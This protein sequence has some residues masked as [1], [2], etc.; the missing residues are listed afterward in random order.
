MVKT[1]VT[2]CFLCLSFLSCQSG[3]KAEIITCIFTEPYASTTYD[4]RLKT[5][6]VTYDVENRRERLRNVF[7]RRTG[8][9]VFQ[10]RDSKRKLIQRLRLCNCGQDGQSD[11]RYAY[12]V[13]WFTEERELSGGCSSSRR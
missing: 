3:A 4:T 11:K 2:T 1:G 7:L 5:F 9:G 13:R 8:S 10:L 12:D 6:A